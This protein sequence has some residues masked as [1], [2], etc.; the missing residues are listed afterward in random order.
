MNI[1]HFLLSL[2][3]VP[4]LLSPGI[5][6]AGDH[7]EIGTSQ[8][9]F[10]SSDWLF[11]VYMDAD[12]NLAGAADANLAQMMEAGSDTKVSILVLLDKN[13]F[14][15]SRLYYVKKNALE[16]V[17]DGGAVIPDTKEVNMGSPETLRNF[18]NFSRKYPRNHT[19]LVL[20][21][22]GNGWKGFC[23]DSQ[24]KDSLNLTEIAEVL[25]EFDIDVLGV[26]ACQGA[27]M[28][29]VYAL[30]NSARYFVGSQKDEPENGWNYTL[31]LNLAKNFQNLTPEK[32]AVAAVD[33]FQQHYKNYSF[34][35]V[36]VALSAINLTKV[37]MLAEA[38]DN[39]SL[40]LSAGSF[41]LRSEIFDARNST[42]TYEGDSRSDVDLGDFAK[43]SLNSS[44]I[45]IRKEAG[46]V[47]SLLN[48]VVLKSCGISAV[49]SSTSVRADNASGLSI[50]F[51]CTSFDSKYM[52]T[53]FAREKNWS[54]F[55]LDFLG[56][57]SL[58]LATLE[59]RVMIENTTIF[60]ENPGN[61]LIYI[62]DSRGEVVWCT[63]SRINYTAGVPDYYEV[64]GYNFT[65]YN[66]KSYLNG[67]FRSERIWVGETRPNIK[68][69]NVEFFREDGVRVLGNTGK[70]PVE[71]RSF[72]F[73]LTLTNDGD[74]NVTT[75]LKIVIGNFTWLENLTVAVNTNLSIW[76]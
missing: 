41:L 27:L 36:P 61:A 53:D 30:R 15:D 54:D 21:D 17:D 31:L 56:P 35:S 24:S 28:E 16:L 67:I 47:L 11:L 72:T 34:L 26:D 14:G 23:T 71:N 37:E 25:E 33:A 2:V 51:P 49:L 62:C 59:V 32:F 57:P 66:G 38:I 68:I 45:L 18:L 50:Y 55:L 75:G 76:H 60:I 70:H 3:L 74:V 65:G 43:K 39:F 42:E 20:W 12:N 19:F 73:K 13:T 4:L 6:T 22:H 64:L 69:G 44:Y 5:S 1:H 40:A 58:P 52:S 63:D 29:V 46:K 7:K 10:Q 48:D 9:H 8:W